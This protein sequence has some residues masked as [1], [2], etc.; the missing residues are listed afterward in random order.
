MECFF[1]LFDTI[2]N[3]LSK[4][5][6]GVGVFAS[7][8]CWANG[9]AAHELWIC[10]LVPTLLVSTWPSCLVK[11]NMCVFH[12]ADYFC[13]CSLLMFLCAWVSVCAH[14]N[15]CPLYPS[16]HCAHTHSLKSLSCHSFLVP[17][18]THSLFDCTHYTCNTMASPVVG[19]QP[20]KLTLRLS[21][22]QTIT[23]Y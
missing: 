17:L 16:H 15:F 14:S 2:C 1:S 18:H 10:T 21:H 23:Y 12:N 7:R 6:E 5:C 4:N 20:I 9:S 3:I 22:S 13:V 11:E 19:L 8:G